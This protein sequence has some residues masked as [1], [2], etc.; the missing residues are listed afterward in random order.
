MV[1]LLLLM[2]SL[3]PSYDFLD[4]FFGFL[5]LVYVIIMRN[6]IHI[7]ELFLGGK[8]GCLFSILYFQFFEKVV[9]R[10]AKVW[11]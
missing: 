1:R 4:L 11:A 10:Y 6:G 7:S 3:I 2:W 5:T 8:S 9:Y